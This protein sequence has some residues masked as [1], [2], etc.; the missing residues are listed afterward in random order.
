M[1]GTLNFV[2]RTQK[3][4][5]NGKAPIY[6]TYS[7]HRVFEYLIPLIGIVYFLTIGKLIAREQNISH[8]GKPGS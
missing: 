8:K 3:T 7:I 5:K 6:L 1:I 2:L 4:L